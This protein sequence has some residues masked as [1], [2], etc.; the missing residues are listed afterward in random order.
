MY[1][2]HVQIDE[3]V[4]EGSFQ[5]RK[6]ILHCQNDNREN[7]KLWCN[8]PQASRLIVKINYK[9]KPSADCAAIIFIYKLY[10]A[11]IC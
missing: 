10:P 5:L 4:C 3:I 7:K 1:Y 11:W 2:F 6:E 9:K 8:R